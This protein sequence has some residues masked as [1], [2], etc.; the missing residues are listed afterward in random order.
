[1]SAS[2]RIFNAVFPPTDEPEALRSSAAPFPGLS[3]FDQ[4]FEQQP[5]AQATGGKDRSQ[6][7]EWAT[8]WGTAICFL[9]LSDQPIDAFEKAPALRAKWSKPLTAES[10][11][12]LEFVLLDDDA[13]PKSG[14]DECLADCDLLRWYFEES[15][16]EHYTKHMLPGLTKV[17]GFTEDSDRRRLA[18]DWPSC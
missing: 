18:N 14:Q 12:A 6:T 9:R 3:L 13:A 17:R 16:V 7:S 10:R 5:A 1:M 15:V 4:H 11:R 8:A 2:D